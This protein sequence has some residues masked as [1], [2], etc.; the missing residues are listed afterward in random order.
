MSMLRKI[1]EKIVDFFGE[2]EERKSERKR[3]LEARKRFK[4]SEKRHLDLGDIPLPSGLWINNPNRLCIYEQFIKNKKV[5]VKEQ[6][7]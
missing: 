4:E 1:A 2:K 3:L 6:R 5:K 7:Q